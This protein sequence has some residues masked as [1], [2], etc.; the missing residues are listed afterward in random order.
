[1]INAST[2]ISSYSNDDSNG[3]L[4]DH[5]YKR[6]FTVDALSLLKA[7]SNK[8]CFESWR[9]VVNVKFDFE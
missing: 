4:V 3:F 2:I 5:G 8:L 7:L 1:M 6:L 9:A